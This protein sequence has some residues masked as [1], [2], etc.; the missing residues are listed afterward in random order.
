MKN[1]MFTKQLPYLVYGFIA[2]FLSFYTEG[3]AQV[4]INTDGSAPSAN[5]ILDLNP[6]V[7]KA[8]V[9]PKMTY[10]Q[11]KAISPALEGMTIYDTEFKTLRLYNGTKWVSLTQQFDIFAPTGLLTAQAPTGSLVINAVATDGSGN[12]YT[13]GSFVGTATFGTVSVTGSGSCTEFFLAKY[14]SSGVAQW[15]QKST[16]NQ[17]SG[18]FAEGKALAVDA[19]GNI[20]I[21]GSFSTFPY[22]TANLTFGGLSSIFS[23]PTLNITTNIFVVKYNSSGVAQWLKNEGGEGDF[24]DYGTGITVD[25]SSNVYVTGY[26][27]PA[28]SPVPIGAAIGGT[29]FPNSTALYEAFVVKYNSSGVGQW[30]KNIDGVSGLTSQATGSGIAVDGSGNV[31][32]SGSFAGSIS[33][34][35]GISNTS[36]GLSDGF[37][38]KYNSAGSFT[39]FT[40]IGGTGN[41][42]CNGLTIDGSGNLYATGSFVST[43]NFSFSPSVTSTSAG[44]DDIFVAKYSNSSANALQWVKRAGGTGSDVGNSIAIDASNNLFVTGSITGA[45]TFGTLP[46]I[47]ASGSLDV[48]MAKYNTNGA[49]QWVLKAGGVGNDSGRGIALDPSNNVYTVG[50]FTASAQFGNTVLAAGTTFLMKYSE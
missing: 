43:A 18:C 5:T 42:F 14:N 17:T 37:I 48:F 40:K 32:I 28:Q 15:V 50:G 29:T 21:T 27:S 31:Y 12:V 41:D 46:T 6:A 10:T 1:I 44:S 36:A 13:T 4:A 33:Y 8:F 19:S 3:V 30:A 9:P 38:A 20:H 26:F 11:I 45:A 23:Y 7:G 22:P 47:T 49:E 2:L 16:S 25:A 24:G 35:S 34:F 39:W